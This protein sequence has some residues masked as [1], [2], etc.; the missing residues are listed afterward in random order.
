MDLLNRDI[1]IVNIKKKVSKSSDTILD[2][3]LTFG[4]FTGGVSEPDFNGDIS[5]FQLRLNFLTVILLHQDILI[6]PDESILP[7]AKV[8]EEMKEIANQ[9]FAKYFS[10]T[11]SYGGR[12]D[13]QNARNVL[14]KAVPDRN[15]FR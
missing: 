8:V 12:S 4:N 11:A 6:T 14:Q 2:L 13:F 9:F 1:I 10:L 3:L 15:H 7:S 5:I